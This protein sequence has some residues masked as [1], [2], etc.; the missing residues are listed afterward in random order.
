MFDKQFLFSADVFG[1]NQQLLYIWNKV[2]HFV[3]FAEPHDRNST[4]I[5]EKL[6]KIPADVTGL[7]VLIVQPLF[8]GKELCGTR[9]IGL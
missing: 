8:L 3:C 7:Q 1:C 5:D 2:F 4:A 9:T 6:L